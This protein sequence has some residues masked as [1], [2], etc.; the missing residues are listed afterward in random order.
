M[1]CLLVTRSGRPEATEINLCIS[2][3]QAMGISYKRAVAETMPDDSYVNEFDFVVI[4]YA[5]GNSTFKGV[6]DNTGIIIPVFMLY[7]SGYSG[8]HA[9]SPGVTLGSRTSLKSEFFDSDWTDSEYA[10]MN[11]GT[12]ALS[13]G[14]A[15]ATIASTEPAAAPFNGTAQTNA[16]RVMVWKTTTPGG[17]SSY[18]SAAWATGHS[19]LPFLIQEAINEGVLTS[20]PR[21]APMVMDIDHIHGASNTSPVVIDETILDVIASYVPTGGVIWSGIHNG[22][23]AL[24]SIPDALVAKLKQYSG[25]PY[26]YCYHDHEYDTLI[27][28]QDANG[29]STLVTKTQQQVQYDADEALW[30]SYGLEFHYPA[31]H[32]S[33][34]NAFDEATLELFSRD[35]SKTSS[36][37]NDTTQAG[38]GFKVFRAIGESAASRRPQVRGSMNH[39]VYATKQ[40]IRG[41]QIVTTW[42]LAFNS[43]VAGSQFDTVT[44]WQNAT[45]FIQ[46]AVSNGMSLYMHTNDFDSTIQ[47]PGISEKAHG[48]ELMKLFSDMGTYL[49]NVAKVFADP[50]DY[51]T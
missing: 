45:R 1:K 3:L 30:N 13:D 11:G 10:A 6:H 16:G 38:Y 14:T 2:S 40:R 47:E 15:I 9:A 49:K 42:D 22:P 23:T 7:C 33:G 37:G 27:Q 35:I 51:T 46:Q 24:P 48:Y 50:M 41:I 12:Y 34:S 17:S 21:R 19:L 20:T 31:Y 32:D 8:N 5:D 39:N 18:F 29:Y 36:P 43:Q 28:T 26:K 44:D 25:A 4:P